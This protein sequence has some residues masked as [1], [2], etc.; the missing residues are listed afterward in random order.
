MSSGWLVTDHYTKDKAAQS[1]GFGTRY[2]TMCGW[3]FL[4]V[5]RSRGAELIGDNSSGTLGHLQWKVREEKV[6]TYAPVIYDV[7]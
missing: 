5:S 6:G 3:E 2:T 1:N 4:S 7:P